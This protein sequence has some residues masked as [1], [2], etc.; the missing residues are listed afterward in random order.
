M[1][2]LTDQPNNN[3][4]TLFLT[5]AL[6][7]SLSAFAGGGGDGA[8]HDKYCAKMKDG[9]LTVMH[10]NMV[11]TSMVMLDNGATLSADG[12]ITDKDGTK[13][14]LRENECITKEGKLW[15]KDMKKDGDMKDKDK[16]MPN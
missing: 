1:F 9:R 11:V 13:R 7:L 15:D 14:M 10:D 5:V 2:Y 4:K 12:T 16:S 8:D 3:M 6:A